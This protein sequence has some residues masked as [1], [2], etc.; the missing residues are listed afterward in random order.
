MPIRIG[1]YPP[2][3]NRGEFIV[4]QFDKRGANQGFMYA[5]VN[6]PAI[7]CQIMNHT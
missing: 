5:T 7:A 3:Y 4:T 6:K 2:P 1:E